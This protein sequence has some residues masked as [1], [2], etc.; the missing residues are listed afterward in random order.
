MKRLGMCVLVGLLSIAA[1]Q[2]DEK[3]EIQHSDPCGPYR[4]LTELNLQGPYPIFC[5]V[6]DEG[7]PVNGLP[8]RPQP[9]AP[10]H[11][12]DKTTLPA[13]KQETPSDQ[14]SGL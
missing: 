10:I 13:S 2:A 5:L 9:V 1:T 7:D 12:T 3:K 4:V 14:K 11:E 8:G 6:I